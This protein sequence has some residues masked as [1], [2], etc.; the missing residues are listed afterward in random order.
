MPSWQA[1][2]MNACTRTLMKPM[3]RFGSVESMR[4][5]TGA[6]DEQQEKMLPEAEV[7]LQRIADFI[8]NSELDELPAEYGS[9]EYEAPK[10]CA[11]KWLPAPLAEKLA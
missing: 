9:N 10:G 11:L 2:L 6:M 3:M 7:A 8:N 1:R 5:M 4:A